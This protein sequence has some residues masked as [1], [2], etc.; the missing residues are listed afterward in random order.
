MMLPVSYYPPIVHF[1]Y[2]FTDR[3]PADLSQ[4]GK[5][6]RI[7]GKKRVERES[8]ILGNG[9]EETISPADFI[10]PH[11]NNYAPS[12][13]GVF[14]E[15]Q[16]LE[17]DTPVAEC[18]HP[19]PLAEII[20]TPIHE[21]HRAPDLLSYPAKINFFVSVD[22]EKTE[23]ITFSLL[24]DINFVTA[25]PCSPSS[26]VR[27]LKSPSSPTLQQID[28]TGSNALGAGSRS[29]YRAGKHFVTLNRSDVF[30]YANE[31]GRPPTA[32]IL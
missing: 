11:E 1:A 6:G 12:P 29:M 4:L 26:R 16:S 32:Q 14:V 30:R 7:W 28:F 2:P 20:A 19:T 13:P 23:T 10:I 3:W 21:N 27:V 31:N 9:D 25:H 8:Y 24:Y 17:L 5:K 22:G 18:V 15:L